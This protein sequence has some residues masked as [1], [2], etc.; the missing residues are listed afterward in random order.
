MSKL[1]EIIEKNPD[2]KNGTVSVRLL[3]TTFSQLTRKIGS[4]VGSNFISSNTGDMLSKEVLV[5]LNQEQ[6]SLKQKLIDWQ[7]NYNNYIDSISKKI[8][9]ATHF[10]YNFTSLVDYSSKYIPNKT[11]ADY[12][13]LTEFV[14]AEKELYEFGHYWGKN[15]MLDLLAKMKEWSKTQVYGSSVQEIGTEFEAHHG[16]YRW[17]IL[18]NAGLEVRMDIET[19]LYH[20]KRWYYVS[21][22][23]SIKINEKKIIKGRCYYRRNNRYDDRIAYGECFIEITRKSLGNN[24]KIDD[25][26][27]IFTAWE[28]GLDKVRSWPRVTKWTNIESPY[29]DI[30]EPTLACLKK[31]VLL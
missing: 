1:M 22:L 21:N 19:N 24:C 26:Y 15:H 9:N 2:F 14:N 30:K 28:K 5:S 23:Q 4:K 27:F 11:S 20:D 31:V 3:D 25:G 17:E 10:E 12:Y 6:L 18:D 16:G 29:F 8:T 7:N 13:L